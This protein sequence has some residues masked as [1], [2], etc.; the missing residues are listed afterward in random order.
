MVPSAGQF[1]VPIWIN[2][3]KKPDVG[4]TAWYSEKKQRKFGEEM[5]GQTWS[6][7]ILICLI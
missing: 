2:E 6:G 7:V 5:K 1:D 3:G 4:D